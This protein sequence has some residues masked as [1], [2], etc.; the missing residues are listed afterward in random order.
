MKTTSASS[1]GAIEKACRVLK[2]MSDGRNIRLIDIADYCGLDRSTTMR[3]L[4]ILMREGM[5]ARDA[6]TK[7]YRLGAEISRIANGVMEEVDW[8]HISRPSLLRLSGE[9]EDTTLMSVLSGLEMVCVDLQMG[10]YPVRANF[11]AIGSRRTLGVGSS[12]L[13]VLAVMRDAEREALLPQIAPR[14]TRYPMLTG[15][16]LRDSI[17]RAQR[18]GYAVMID[19]VVQ[20]MGGIAVPI[21][22]RD[23]EVC[24]ALAISALSDR[25]LEREEALAVALRREALVIEQALRQA[26]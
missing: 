7:H 10:D 20:R 17:A 12:G 16:F 5:V 25:V 14:V 15:E 1:T 19:A 2:A 4:D 18:N 24:A 21:R 9:F 6:E 8:R 23:G 11:Q 26:K 13:A 3:V 22:A